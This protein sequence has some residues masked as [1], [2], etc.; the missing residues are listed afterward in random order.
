MCAHACVYVLGTAFANV[1]NVEYV[2]PCASGGGSSSN[3]PIGNVTF[4]MLLLGDPDLGSCALRGLSFGSFGSGSFHTPPVCDPSRSDSA[5]QRDCVQPGCNGAGCNY[6]LQLTLGRDRTQAYTLQV[7]GFV[8]GPCFFTVPVFCS[9]PTIPAFCPLLALLPTPPF[10]LSSSLSASLLLLA[11][12][13]LL[14]S[15]LC[16]CS[17]CIDRPFPCN[18]SSNLMFLP[19]CARCCSPAPAPRRRCCGASC[20]A[21]LTSFPAFPASTP[22]RVRAAQRALTA[23]AT[24]CRRPC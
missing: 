21:P 16:A 18:P 20:A 10:A 15:P 1:L 13:F 4:Q 17:V 3:P 22:S 14:R 23:A 7:C 5:S 9:F 11:C 8:V 6:T 12:G 24:L 2:S 19:R